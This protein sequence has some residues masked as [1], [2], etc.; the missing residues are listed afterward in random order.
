MERE[1]EAELQR[2]PRLGGFVTQGLSC[3]A[4][5]RTGPNMK[6]KLLCLGWVKLTGKTS[7][8]CKQFKPFGKSTLDLTDFV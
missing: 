7:L 8:I 4:W 3:G 1:N 6:R 5:R 2:Q